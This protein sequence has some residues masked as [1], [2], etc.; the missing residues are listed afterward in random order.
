MYFPAKPIHL[1]SRRKPEVSPDGYIAL[2][3]CRVLRPKE[4]KSFVVPKETLDYEPLSRNKRKKSPSIFH[5]E[6]DHDR[7]YYVPPFAVNNIR[8][9]S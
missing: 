3:T 1:L 8:A 4:I 5:H 2:K 9:S 6:T 7:G